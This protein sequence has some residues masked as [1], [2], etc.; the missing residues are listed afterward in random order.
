MSQSSYFIY[1]LDN[2]NEILWIFKKH[3]LTT[4]PLLFL[5]S[6]IILIPSG[7]LSHLASFSK[8]YEMYLDFYINLSQGGGAKHKHTVLYVPTQSCLNLC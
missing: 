4:A 6:L 1:S 8:L 7:C 2:S 5:L 3:L